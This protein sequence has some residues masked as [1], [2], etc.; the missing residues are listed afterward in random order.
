MIKQ[1]RSTSCCLLVSAACGLLI[2]SIAGCG[3]P[4]GTDNEQRI[5]FDDWMPGKPRQS[6]RELPYSDQLDPVKIFAT[7]CAGC[8]GADGRLGP[9]PPL[10]DRL[11]LHIYTPEA[12]LKLLAGGR[13][14]GLMPAF[15]ANHRGGLTEQ[16]RKILVESIWNRWGSADGLPQNIP[17]YT[18]S[19]NGNPVAGKQIFTA[20]CSRCHGTDGEGAT[21]GALNRTAFLDLVSDQLLRRIMITGRPDLGCPDFVESGTKS[22]SGKPLSSDDIANVVAFMRAWQTR[23]SGKDEKDT[24]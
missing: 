5:T 2:A 12:M 23:Q 21:A 18:A 1:Y 17:P 6:E 9:A 24:R 22:D 13:S 11:F 8:H 16:Q 14:E 10:N 4:S 19:G 3:S 7:S 20:A 15:V